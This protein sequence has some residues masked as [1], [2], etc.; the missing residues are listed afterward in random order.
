MPE[1]RLGLLPTQHSDILTTPFVFG[2]DAWIRTMIQGFKVLCPAFRR[3]RKT[4]G[5][6]IANL[7]RIAL[8]IPLCFCEKSAA[9]V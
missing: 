3:R 2:S 6:R 7:A 9:C 4:W 8:K 1:R 5:G